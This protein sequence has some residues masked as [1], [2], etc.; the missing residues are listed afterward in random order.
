[1]RKIDA[2]LILLLLAMLV[3]LVAAQVTTS[4]APTASW[5]PATDT[6]KSSSILTPTRTPKPT[7]IPTP[8][9]TPIVTQYSVWIYGCG[10]SH[11]YNMVYTEVAPTVEIESYRG[12]YR[13]DMPQFWGTSGVDYFITGKD[14][15]G[16]SYAPETIVGSGYCKVEITQEEHLLYR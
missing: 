11:Q 12:P 1:M 10:W 14:V 9:P 7:P 2:I 6:S 13:L 15:I 5:K 3:L 8:A 16:A 4:T